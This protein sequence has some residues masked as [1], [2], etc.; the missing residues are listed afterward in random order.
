MRFASSLKLV[1]IILL[2]IFFASSFLVPAVFAD[3]PAGA[4]GTP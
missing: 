3:D 4:G 1:S 2:A